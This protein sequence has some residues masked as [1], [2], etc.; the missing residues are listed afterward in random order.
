MNRHSFFACALLVAA[1][2]VNASHA[3]AAAPT[4]SDVRATSTTAG[5]TSY[6]TQTSGDANHSIPLAYDARNNIARARSY[7]EENELGRSLLHMERA[8]YLRP[9]NLDIR[10]G[11]AL[12]NYQV[13]RARMERFA[14]DRLTQGEPRLLWTWRMFHAVPAKVWAWVLLL[15]IWFSCGLLLLR[16]RMQRSLAR[17]AVAGGL[18]FSICTAITGLICWI[19]ALTTYDRFRPGIITDPQVVAWSAPDALI[20]PVAN[21]DLYDGAVV[22]IRTQEEEWTE[23]ELVDR[24]RVWIPHTSVHAVM[25]IH[26]LTSSDEKRR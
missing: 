6:D 22:L 4:P 9:F 8:R 10:Q 13:Q 17:D 21:P 25:I 5:D 2:A 1:M 26:D 15:G 23:V 16:L 11:L 7:A 24:E 19:G 12:V 20:T 3:L 14:H 18:V